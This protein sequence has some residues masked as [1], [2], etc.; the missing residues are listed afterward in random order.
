MS[1]WSLAEEVSLCELLGQLLKSS[2]KK[3]IL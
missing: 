2:L 3:E 1:N